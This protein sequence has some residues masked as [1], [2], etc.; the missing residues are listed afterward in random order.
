MR[1]G[2]ATAGLAAITA[3]LGAS[4]CEGDACEAEAPSF[5]L[6]L[7]ADG[8]SAR[9]VVI[10]LAGTTTRKREA[11]DLG[12][13]LADGATSI[14][15]EVEEAFIGAITISAS[16]HSMPA[17]EGE[18]LARGSGS[19]MLG[20]NGCNRY[21]LELV[22]EGGGDCVDTADANTIALYPME[23]DLNDAA[24]AHE[25]VREGDAAFEAGHCGQ[26]LQLPGAPMVRGHAL[27]AD[28]PDFDLSEGSL[29]L[30]LRPGSAESSR[31][32]GVVSRASAGGVGFT[33][34]VACSG[35]LIARLGD[36]YACAEAP[37]ADG[38][39]SFVGVN[40]G[41]GGLEL[42]VDGVRASR[43]DETGL[44]GQSCQD[45]VP[46][47]GTSEAGLSGGNPWILG[48]SADGSEAGTG[49]PLSL[50]FRSG[51]IDAFRISDVRRAF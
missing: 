38:R 16:T 33:L 23:G 35:A 14:A 28:S 7:T 51:T 10:E 39:W 24:G 42:W 49:A 45:E 22:D 44:F 36:A 31:A 9:S 34:Y 46:C 18:V 15:V 5:Q 19:F 17:G 2:L 32:Q 6:D 37:L 40:F 41:A 11:F 21:S 26:A 30:W 48:A 47:G 29:D 25:G 12:M 13:E 3:A 1:V 50:P 27:V 4:G 20:A 43:T 8:G